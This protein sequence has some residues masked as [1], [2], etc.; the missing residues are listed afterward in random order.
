MY[1]FKIYGN[2][3]LL[4]LPLLAIHA[5]RSTPLS[6]YPKIEDLFHHLLEM[7]ISIGSGWHS[8]AEKHLLRMFQRA[9]RANLL[10]FLARRFQDYALPEHLLS[11]FRDDKIAIIEPDVKQQRINA[12]GVEIR[13]TLVDD[14]IE[15]HLFFYIH[16]G[17]R[18]EARLHKLAAAGKHVF[19]LDVPRHHHY[20]DTGGMFV[21]AKHPEPLDDVLQES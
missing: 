2:N 18:L 4:T 5:S 16:P 20:V 17:G 3:R 10:L 7:N 1:H 14:L 8:P 9:T 21:D 11:L 13:D 12:K 15:N 6:V 19:L